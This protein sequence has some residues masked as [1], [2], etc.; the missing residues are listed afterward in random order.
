MLGAITASDV[1]PM[2]D[3]V[4]AKAPA[5]QPYNVELCYYTTA[6]NE[7]AA[8]TNIEGTGGAIERYNSVRISTSGLRIRKG[9]GTNYGIAQNAIAPGV[10]TIVAESSGAGS[11]KGWG[12]L[13]SGAGW[14]SLDYA[15]KV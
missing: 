8:I 9:P 10:Y 3:F 2:T 5:T 4:Q 6:A 13:K 15:T 7:S 14:I 11:T 12:K 1:R